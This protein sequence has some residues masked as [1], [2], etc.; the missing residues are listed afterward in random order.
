MAR[1]RTIKPEFF[2]SED[3]VSLS[4]FARLLFIALWCEADREGRFQWK[5]KTFKMRYFPADDFNI[6]L[7]CNELIAAGVVKLYGD[8]LAYVPSF[9]RHQHVN[10]RESAS[11]LP[12]PAENMTRQ[13]RV[14][15]RER[16]ANDAQVGREGKERKGKDDAWRHWFD[17][18]WKAYPRK[19]AKQDAEKAFAKINPDQPLFDSIMAALASAV[20]SPDWLKDGGQFIP[21]PASWLNGRRW[22]DLPL[23]ANASAS[24]G[25]R[26]RRMLPGGTL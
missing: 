6:E 18:F 11:T 7:A 10:P 16:T 12:D 5:P 9:C 8:G 24:D 22:E 20:R 4:P 14:S 13:A 26:V 2:T 19:V 3:V 17:Q 15:T 23:L 21:Y 1:I 25:G